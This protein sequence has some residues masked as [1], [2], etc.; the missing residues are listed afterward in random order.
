MSILELSETVPRHADAVGDQIM[1]GLVGGGLLGTALTIERRERGQV[2]FRCFSPMLHN[3]P[4]YGE[5]D[6]LPTDRGGVT[7]S[8]RLSCRWL[9]FRGFGLAFVGAAALGLLLWLASS[10]VVGL[11]GGLAVW[12]AGGL[13]LRAAARARVVSQARAYIVNTKYLKAL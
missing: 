12:L 8:C 6:I 3:T 9:A 5:I 1:F 2:A 13:A 11:G 7:V 4:E 10:W